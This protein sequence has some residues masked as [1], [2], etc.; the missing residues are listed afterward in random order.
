MA[1]IESGGMAVWLLAVGQT[2]IYAGCYYSFPALLPDL[3]AAT[4]WTKGEL[5]LGP[6]LAFLIMAALTPFTGRLVD[7]GLGGEMLIW[8]PGLCALGVAGLGLAGSLAGWLAL[9]A[10]IGVAQAGSLYE[11]CFAFLTRRLGDGARAAITS[12]T[13]VAGFAGTLAFPLGHWLGSALGGQG[14]LIVFAGLVLLAM[15]LN[16]LAVRQLRQ[17]ERADQAVPPNPPG[18]LQA[19][20][21]KPAFWIIAVGFLAVY[22]NHGILITYALILFADRGAA[23]GLAAL[24]AACIGPAQVA[25]R[26]V[27]LAAGARVTTTQATMASLGGIVVAG[28]LLWLAGAAPL[29]IFGFA[30]AQGAGLGLTSILRPVLIAETLGRQGF[31]A[32]SGAAAVAPILASAAAPSVGAGLLALGGPGLVYAVCLA[33]AVTGLALMALLLLRRERFDG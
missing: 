26:L 4:G 6:T 30:V 33:L 24:A 7:R 27:L 31:G 12:V 1:V 9:W 5:A 29:L 23:P 8:L 11:T 17:R 10:L 20:L 32:I 13:L 22:L 21:R 14:A 25:G 19:A 3:V 28:V 15:P 18:V 2:L 16:A